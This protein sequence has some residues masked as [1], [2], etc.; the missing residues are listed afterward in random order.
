MIFF[1]D[2]LLLEPSF[3]ILWKC[4]FFRGLLFFSTLDYLCFCRSYFIIR[5][6]FQTKFT[7]NKKNKLLNT[8]LSNIRK[9]RDR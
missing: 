8:D 2:S 4:K 5:K 3:Y 1:L 7:V 9:I 6:I